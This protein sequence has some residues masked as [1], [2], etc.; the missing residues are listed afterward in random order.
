MR[1]EQ[2]FERLKTLIPDLDMFAQMPMGSARTSSSEGIMDLH[3]DLIGRGRDHDHI[4]IALAHNWRHD[5]GDT[6]ADPDMRVR[7]SIGSRQAEALAFQQDL[8]P[9]Y[10]CVYENGKL[11]VP[12]HT[13]DSINEFL[14]Q[15]LLNC[16]K[17]GHSFDPATAQIHG[18]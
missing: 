8:P 12:E 17:Q 18:D 9:I 14:A 16:I 5:S 1:H 7:V 13:R 15:W 3:L 4:V 10:Q 6:I 2:I 11:V